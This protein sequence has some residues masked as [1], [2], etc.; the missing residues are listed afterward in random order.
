MTKYIVYVYIF[1]TKIASF[2]VLL[3]GLK[4]FEIFFIALVIL[5]YTT[6]IILRVF[7][8]QCKLLASKN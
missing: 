1:Y 6:S 2:K 3:T 7:P 5:F 8:S 4:F